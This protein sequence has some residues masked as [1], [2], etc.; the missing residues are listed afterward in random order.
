MKRAAIILLLAAASVRAE[1]PT[2]PTFRSFAGVFVG[3]SDHDYYVDSEL[4]LPLVQLAPV[5]A[6]YRYRETT[7]FIRDLQGPQ[8]EVLARRQEG[9]LRLAITDHIQLIGIGGY[10]SAYR[11]DTPGY[12]AAYAIGGGL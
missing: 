11:E 7:P 4:R 8:A 10:R 5:T 6:D 3:G 9:E 12:Q 2:R 1:D